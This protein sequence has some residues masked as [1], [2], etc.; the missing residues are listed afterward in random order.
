MNPKEFVE[1]YGIRSLVCCF[2][3]GK[4]SLVATHYVM[5]E[6][7]DCNVDKYIVF[8]NTGVMLPIAEPFVKDICQQ[9]GWNLTILHG[10]FFEKA[11]RWGMPRMF[12]RWCCGE[13]KIKPIREFVKTLKLQRGEVVGLRKQESKKREKIVREI[14]YKKISHSFGYA[15]IFTWS[16][17]DV[18][19]YIKEHK[20]PM[21]P[22]YKLGIKETC[23]CG[24]FTSRKQMLILKA[25]FPEFFQQF[26]EFEKKLRKGS[27]FFFQNKPVYAHDLAKQKTLTDMVK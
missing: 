16:H 14:F 1:H 12:H 25:Q 18:S 6:L 9:F 10:H 21:P 13:C 22:N 8:V 3:G 23:Q 7:E 27:V 17:R 11:E 5:T 15:P 2:S 26:I 19:N 24:V 20:L 4:D